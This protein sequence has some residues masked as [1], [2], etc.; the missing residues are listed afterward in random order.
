MRP[1]TKMVDTFPC[2]A[3]RIEGVF[4]PTNT[5]K[6]AATNVQKI[7]SYLQPD[8]YSLILTAFG[9]RLMVYLEGTSVSS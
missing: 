4:E 6:A 8:G 2:P 1:Y 7:S 3:L 9:L 5:T